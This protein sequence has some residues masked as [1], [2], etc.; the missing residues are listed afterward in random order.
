MTE[1]IL[2]HY[3]VSPFAE[4]IRCVL[5]YKQ[6][7]WQSVEIPT[8]MP[9]PDLTALTGG[10]RKTP[11]LQIGCDVYCDTPLIAR[12]LDRLHPARPVFQAAQAAVAAAAGRWFDRYLF[13]AVIGQL[14]DPEVAPASAEAL[15]GMAAAAAFVADRTPMMKGAPVRPPRSEDG[16]V[17]VEQVLEQLETQLEHG[18]PFLL[19]PQVGWADFCAYH[20]LWAMRQNRVLSAR[21]SSY[22]HVMAWLDR[23]RAFGHGSP[24]PLEAADALTVARSAQ[25]R[26]PALPSAR[27]ERLSVGAEVEIAA[28][29]YALEPS[30]GR[31]VY[32]G[33]D[34][35]AIERL[36]ER[37]GRVVVHFP[38]VGFK[39]TP[40]S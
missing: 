11:V 20:P 17:L 3:A 40:R 5:G 16:R 7:A 34:E 25:P 35:L 4:K 21:L 18:S 15:G 29:D 23:M 27:L 26:P 30:A 36:D 14:F 1:I 24:T 39:V 28:A 31:L 2:H 33:P 12:A 8:V 37:A 32:V 6:L 13:L 22:A 9:K 10:Y 19:G 38:R